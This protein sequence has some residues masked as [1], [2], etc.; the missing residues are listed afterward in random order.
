MVTS[1]TNGANFANAHSVFVFGTDVYVAGYENNGST[2]VVKIWNNG[3]PVSLT[4]G[5]NDAVGYSIFVK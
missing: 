1:L 2:N 4:N 3:I 5:A